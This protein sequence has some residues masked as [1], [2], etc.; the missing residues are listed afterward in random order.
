VR[1]GG[2]RAKAAP[3]WANVLLVALRA[4]PDGGDAVVAAL[5]DDGPIA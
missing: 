3:G 2:E 4:D 1:T 5:F